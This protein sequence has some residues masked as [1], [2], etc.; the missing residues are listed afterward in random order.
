[1]DLEGILLS[2]VRQRKIILCNTAYMW[3]VKK[4]SSEHNIK[5]ADS[6]IQRRN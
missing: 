5:E 1:M 3:H 4:K 2:E 6:Q